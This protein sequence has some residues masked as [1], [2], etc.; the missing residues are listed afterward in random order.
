MQQTLKNV[1]IYIPSKLFGLLKKTEAGTG[2]LQQVI[3]DV[4][5]EGLI[6]EFVCDNPKRAII[7]Q[8]MSSS[9]YYAC[10]YC[11][12]KAIPCPI[13]KTKKKCELARKRIELQ[14]KAIDNRITFL[15]DCPGTSASKKKDDQEIKQL[16]KIKQSLELELSTTEPQRGGRPVWPSDT[17]SSPLRTIEEVHGILDF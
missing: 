8:C 4:C 10:E 9:S 17:Y 3:N 13:K 5:S 14:A 15:N 16:R 7:K 6:D 11:F 2:Q 12:G 1:A